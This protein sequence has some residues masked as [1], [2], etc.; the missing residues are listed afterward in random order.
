MSWIKVVSINIAITFSLLGFLL[1]TPPILFYLSKSIEA[2]NFDAETDK[3]S[4]LD[5][6]LEHDWVNDH[7][8]EY[9]QLSSTYYDFITWRRDDFQGKT[10]NINNGIRNTNKTYNQN[11]SKYWF[12]GGST[13]WGTGVSDDFTYPSLFAKYTGHDVTNFGESGYIARQSV[14]YLS[15][16]LIRN[17]IQDLS[18]TNV[19]FYDGVNDVLQRCRHEIS[20]LGTGREAQ[21]QEILFLNGASK[22]G[23]SRL[24]SQLQDFL[25]S[26]LNKI[27]Y[28]STEASYFKDQYICST[29][30]TRS[31]EIAESLVNTWQIASDLVRS[32]GGSF[33]AVLR[34]VAF[35]GIPNIAYL[36]ID[37][38]NNINLAAQ[39]HAV[40]PLIIE[41]AKE[42]NIRFVNLSSAYDQCANCYIDF[43]HVGPEGHKILTRKLISLFDKH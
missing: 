13:T 38:P 14:A 24:F 28:N 26:M 2:L 36:E 9:S 27:F 6:Y 17:N 10:I 12:F 43:C 33:T 39:Y 41:I 37:S 5:L 21:I 31:F 20:S 35:I 8:A 22:Y 16:Y 11:S 4:S 3:R 40:Y 42:R 19:I 15:N 18:D 30:S 1:L 7:F 34:P 25:S 32:R 23:F 29:D